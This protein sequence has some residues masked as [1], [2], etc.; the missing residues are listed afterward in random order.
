MTVKKE[1]IPIIELANGERVGLGAVEITTVPHLS[2]LQ[3]T[4]LIFTQKVKLFIAVSKKC[5]FLHSRINKII[6]YGHFI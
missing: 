3:M 2:I 6:E 1:Y 5:L 4:G